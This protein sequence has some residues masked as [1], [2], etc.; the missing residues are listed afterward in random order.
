MP[1]L[2]LRIAYQGT[3]YAGWQL[4]AHT[5][6]PQP[7]TIQGELERAVVSVLDVPR[8]PIVGCSRTDSG[9]HAEDQ[10][11]RLDIPAG[12]ERINWLRVL[13]SRLPEGTP[14]ARDQYLL[15]LKQDDRSDMVF[16]NEDTGWGFPPYFKF[17]SAEIQA[18]STDLVGKS[19]LIK[20]YGWRS[21]IFRLFPNVLS[22]ASAPENPSLTSY[23]RVFFFSLWVLAV[24]WVF[25]RWLGLFRRRPRQDTDQPAA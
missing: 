15:F 23:T 5:G 17:D 4:Q 22:V 21:K 9:V 25:P 6:V 8:I 16:R 19:V 20:F 18:Q 10:I 13:N 1:R 14:D 2:R 7:P 11:C 24:V 3:R 12:A